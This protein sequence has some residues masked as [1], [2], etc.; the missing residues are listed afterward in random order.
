VPNTGINYIGWWNTTNELTTLLKTQL[1]AVWKCLTRTDSWW[2]ITFHVWTIAQYESSTFLTH[3]HHWH[4]SPVE[5]VTTSL[6]APENDVSFEI[7]ASIILSPTDM[8][9][10]IIFRRHIYWHSEDF[11]SQS[12]P[13]PPAVWERT[14]QPQ[15]LIGGTI[16]DQNTK[17]QL[18]PRRVVD[19]I[20]RNRE[21]KS[22]R[23]VCPKIKGNWSVLV[24]LTS[25][26]DYYLRPLVQF[27]PRKCHG[28]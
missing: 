14:E 19:A 10:N 23:Y 20:N 13:W 3:C 8:W 24:E 5:S 11:P 28:H 17:D 1:T 26:S 7:A 4:W 12:D 2:N 9:D 21:D 18:F 6:G 15:W 27:P 16:G 25:Y 22:F